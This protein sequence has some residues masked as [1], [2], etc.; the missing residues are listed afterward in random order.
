VT[1]APEPPLDAASA[2]DRRALVGRLQQ[3]D[4][5]AFRIVYEC[6]RAK[7][8]SFLYR[9]SGDEQV[10]RDLGQETW[11]RLAANAGRLRDDSDP[12]AWLFTVARNLHT[13]HRRW[14]ILSRARLLELSRWTKGSSAETA[15]EW[16]D[17]CAADARLERA[18][19]GLPI[20]YREVVLLVCVEGFASVDVA[21]MLDIEPAAV[22]QRL[23]RARAKLKQALTPGDAP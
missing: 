22:R 8:H 5:A 18:I 20:K 11:L 9:L 2:A 13:S 10:A 3:R 12:G 19:T 4:P 17:E 15:P 16:V 7:L 14:S 1:P 23:T 21:R 6:Y